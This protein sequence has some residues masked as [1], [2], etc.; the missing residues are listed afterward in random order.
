MNWNTI[1]PQ[2]ARQFA[3]ALIDGGPVVVLE[4]S[5]VAQGLPAPHNLEAAFGCEEAIRAA[6]GIPA[7]VAVREGALQVGL[8]EAELRSLPG[9]GTVMLATFPLSVADRQRAA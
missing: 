1:T 9:K 2:Q 5:I 7:T 8:S 3:A 6:G 4:T